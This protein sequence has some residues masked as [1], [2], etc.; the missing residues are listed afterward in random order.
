[1]PKAC[2]TVA[3]LLAAHGACMNEGESAYWLSQVPDSGM[4]AGSSC[5]KKKKET[6]RMEFFNST[7]SRMGAHLNRSME[8][9][10]P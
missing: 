7:G 4:N 10:A 9:G 3:H 2:N 5:F 8:D 1:M 6:Q